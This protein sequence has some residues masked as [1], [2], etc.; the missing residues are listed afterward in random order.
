MLAVAMV[1]LVVVVFWPSV[2]TPFIFDDTGDIVH[3]ADI[4][5]LWPPSWLFAGPPSSNALAG[6]P[7]SAL[8]F[9]LSYAWGGLEVEGY[10]VFNVL[11]HAA[12][13]LLLFGLVRRTLATPRMPPV[14]SLE[15]TVFAAAVTALWAVH[16]L[17]T[18]PVTY[19]I[20]RTELLAASLYLATL[21]SA[22]RATQ[23]TRPAPWE[24]LAVLAAALG[25][26]SKETMIS[27]PLAV[28][29]FDWIFLERE[30]LSRRRRLYLGLAAS[31][32]VLGLLLLSGKQASVALHS[33]DQLSPL[34]YL[35]TQGRA[36]S[37]YLRLVAWPSPLV[38]AYDWPIHTPAAQGLP[39]F[40]WVGSLFVASAWAA[41]KRHW[42]GFV[43]LAFFLIL[44][45]SSSVIPLPS[46][47]AAERRMYLPLA[48]AVTLL[49]A[50]GRSALE[51]F[52]PR[53]S[54]PALA[55]T[56][57]AAAVVALSLASRD[58]IHDYRSALS[59]WEDAARKSPA[60]ATTQN[61][62]ARELMLEKRFAEAVPHLQEAIRL[63]P[64]LE[65]PRY[66]LGFALLSTG[67]VAGAVPHLRDAV[68]M[69]PTHA[70][71]QYHLGQALVKTADLEGAVAAYKEATRLSPED[72][73]ILVG[74]SAVLA[75]AGDTPGAVT[76]LQNAIR[77]AP[78]D[79]KLY[80]L[81]ASLLVQ[82]G[83]DSEA[84]AA[85]TEAVRV[86][87]G[88]ALGHL[89]LGNALAAQGDVARAV[90]EYLQAVRVGPGDPRIRDMALSRMRALPASAHARLHAARS[91]PDP[92]VRT[93]VD[94]ALT[95]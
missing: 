64:E 65:P 80:N 56:L 45:P 5:Q 22:V 66:L 90:D 6:R 74:L 59:I 47:V 51:R 20:Q 18:E 91:D 70:D 71:A 30:S 21:Y 35:W 85:L 67:D 36:I 46:E 31:W 28:L 40:L 23:E 1:L 26:A 14:S 8:T 79:A 83:S 34:G 7:F 11:L 61:N 15:A 58:R 76:A 48:C 37:R 84:L 19:A 38:I 53:D 44:A 82:A 52:A 2:K 55:G 72:K 32:T 63:Q 95:P 50:G 68:R 75:K 60:R 4:R 89:N 25:M 57:V 29:L 33:E 24:I 16:P 54:R 88:Y 62:V 87:P 43:G 13:A 69:N 41:W 9:A 92:A 77:L 73:D 10:H 78:G 49:V 39:G 94:A 27:A 93:L 86:D 81:L 3:N 42:L 17:V 12:S